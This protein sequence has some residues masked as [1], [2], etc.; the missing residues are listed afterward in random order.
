MT[1]PLGGSLQLRYT[2]SCS[3]L[4]SL[5]VRFC[6]ATWDAARKFF[7]SE[8]I[9]VTLSGLSRLSRPR[10]LPMIAYPAWGSKSSLRNDD[11]FGHSGAPE[12]DW[13]QC[14]PCLLSTLKCACFALGQSKIR[15]SGR[16]TIAME[17]GACCQAAGDVAAVPRIRI[18]SGFKNRQLVSDHFLYFW[19]LTIFTLCNLSILL[20][21]F[22]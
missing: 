14:C 18:R 21:L 19:C 8:S 13:I 17:A 7:S 12:P 9:R 22:Y 5:E 15:S 1:V 16:A 4:Q 20:T 2:S 11:L 6:P 10:Y 3:T